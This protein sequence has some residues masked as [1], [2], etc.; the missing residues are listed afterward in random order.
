MFVQQSDQNWVYFTLKDFKFNTATSWQR[1]TAR[2]SSIALTGSRE[3][4]SPGVEEKQLEKKFFP[5]L[6]K[7]FLFMRYSSNVFQGLFSWRET[8]ESNVQSVATGVPCCF[9]ATSN[10]I[11]AGF[12][13]TKS[14][15]ISPSHASESQSNY[16][17]DCQFFI[18]PIIDFKNWQTL[19]CRCDRMQ[20]Q[21]QIK[22]RVMAR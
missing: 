8:C 10:D 13:E 12:Q 15:I 18:V 11:T 14:F 1:Y 5:S 21:V 20:F 4:L 2:T 3:M 17:K 7:F 22:M 16:A 19:H 6:S 9:P